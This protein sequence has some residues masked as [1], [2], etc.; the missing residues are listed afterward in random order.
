MDIN[1][2]TNLRRRNV[3]PYTRQNRKQFVGEYFLLLRLQNSNSPGYAC[4]LH[5]QYTIYMTS[6]PNSQGSCIMGLL[7]HDGYYFIIYFQ[8][9]SL[10]YSSVLGFWQ[11]VAIAVFIECVLTY[12]FPFFSND[13]LFKL[14]EFNKNVS[15]TPL[16]FIISKL[17]QNTWPLSID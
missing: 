9:N 15:Y 8:L 2:S 10:G 6:W 16:S 13:I 1:K 4:L 7:G 11:T 3:A 12:I 5:V 14:S 17:E